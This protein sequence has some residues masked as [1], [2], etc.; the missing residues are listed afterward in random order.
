[1]TYIAET[2]D[3]KSLF[4]GQRAWR[5]KLESIPRVLTTFDVKSSI[6]SEDNQYVAIISLHN[7][8]KYSCINIIQRKMF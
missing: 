6:K 8:N 4:F 7:K 5:E 2:N 3:N 1:M